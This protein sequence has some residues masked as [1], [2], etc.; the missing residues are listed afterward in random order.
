[1]PEI[2]PKPGICTAEVLRIRKGPAVSF[3]EIGRLARGDRF[4]VIGTEGAWY[5]IRRGSI[6]G[7]VHGDYVRLIDP[8]P[9]PG[10][11]KDRPELRQVALPAATDTQVRPTSGRGAAEKR[12]A[13]A[14]NSYGGLLQACG[15][16]LGVDPRTAIA[17][18]MVES[19]GAGFGPD[20]RMIIRF[21]NH[22]FWDYWGK[23][24][25]PRFQQF[26]RFDAS[27][28]WLAHQFRTTPTGAWRDVHQNQDS[29][30]KTLAF[31]R[32]LDESAALR[33]ISMGLAQVM[34]FNHPRLG[35]DN[36]RVMFDAMQADV[37]FQ[38]LGFFDF[39]RGDGTGSP[40]IDGLQ[41]N[42]FAAFASLYNGAGKAAEYGGKLE[43]AHEAVCR[44]LPLV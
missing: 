34:G 11:L 36:V 20:G 40:M 42:R 44:V 21:E 31:A 37:R 15:S 26:F 19:S 17:V 25:Q 41:R 27:R 43:A 12:A 23:R 9:T 24:D 29:E 28:R 3:T 6:E 5:R 14:W 32:T 33:S 16:I 30:W 13:S 1:M 35:Y 8:A 39:L 2:T 18:L 38:I 4:D 10:Y 22:Q 7:F